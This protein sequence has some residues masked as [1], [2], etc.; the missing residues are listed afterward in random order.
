MALHKAAEYKRCLFQWNKAAGHQETEINVNDPGDTQSCLYEVLN[1]LHCAFN[2]AKE[3]RFFFQL[4]S[5]N[6]CKI[7][8]PLDPVLHC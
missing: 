1:L 4:G 5:H 2:S 3:V 7:I 6:I 8:L